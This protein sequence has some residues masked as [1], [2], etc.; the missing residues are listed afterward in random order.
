ML[1]K[2]WIIE[3]TPFSTHLSRFNIIIKEKKPSPS[4]DISSMFQSKLWLKNNTLGSPKEQEASNKT[5]KQIFLFAILLLI[6]ESW[7]FDCVLFYHVEISQT[8]MII[9]A[10]LYCWEARDE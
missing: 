8:T 9:V 7:L 1:E 4:L 6:K 3:K 5:H 10:Y 2:V